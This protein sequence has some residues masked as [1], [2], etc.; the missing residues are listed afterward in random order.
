[1]HKILKYNKMFNKCIQQNQIINFTFKRE[2]QTQ[3]STYIKK[4]EQTKQLCDTNTVFF[5]NAHIHCG[6]NPTSYVNITT[7]K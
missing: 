6:R 2:L 1:M 5:L 7:S 3:I 4:C